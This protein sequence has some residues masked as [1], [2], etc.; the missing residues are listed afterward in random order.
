MLSPAKAITV[1][2]LVFATGGVL[3]VAQPFAQQGSVPGAI[4][5]T[6]L[7]APAPSVE[8][9]FTIWERAG[10]RGEREP[11]EDLGST[12]QVIFDIEFQSS[13]PRLS[14]S[15]TLNGTDWFPSPTGPEGGAVASE[16]GF[17]TIRLA[18]DEGRWTGTY[19]DIDDITPVSLT[20]EEGYEGLV[21]SVVMDFGSTNDQG[22]VLT[23]A[24]APAFMLAEPPMTGEAG[25]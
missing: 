18:N 17:G 6:T 19:I 11:I 21:A 8:G 15:G 20:G 5:D 24:I 13:D 25:Q 9:S 2:A 23:G 12:E 4:I 3:L 10:T 22:F 7:M 14:G 16:L 1:G